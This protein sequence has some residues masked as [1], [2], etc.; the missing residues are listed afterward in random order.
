MHRGGTLVPDGEQPMTRAEAAAYLKVKPDTV[1]LYVSRGQLR[2]HGRKKG[3]RYYYQSDLDDFIHNIRDDEDE[4][5][6][7]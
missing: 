1:S 2:A 7:E 6:A 5:E 4:D 3:R